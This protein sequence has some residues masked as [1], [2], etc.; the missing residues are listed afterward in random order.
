VW[1]WWGGGGKK[2]N[3]AYAWCQVAE[4]QSRTKECP[5]QFTAMERIVNARCNVNLRGQVLDV[6]CDV[7]FKIL[8]ISINMIIDLIHMQNVHG[9]TSIM[10]DIIIRVERQ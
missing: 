4:A 10:H 5:V 2:K 1:G 9:A 8:A 3:S 7:T 6:C